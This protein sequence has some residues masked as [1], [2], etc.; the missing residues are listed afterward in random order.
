MN[1]EVKISFLGDLCPIN[2]VDNLV[3][4]NDL[5]NFSE[6]ANLL[7]NKDL[8]IAN[9]ECPLTKSKN[10]I[11]KIG[12]NLKGNPDSVKLLKYLSINLTAL[13]NNHIR[14]YGKQ[15][16]AD[17]FD[18]LNNNGIEYI[19]AGN[20]L[21]EARKPLIKEIKGIKIGFINICE[22]EFN[23]AGENDPGA[24]PD[25]LIDTLKT[26][27]SIRTLVDFSIL[28]Y[29]GGIEYYNLPS[30]ILQK[31][32]RFYASKGVDLIISHHT[33]IISGFEIFDNT[34]IFYGLGNFIFDMGKKKK[35]W[36]ETILINVK[37]RKQSK[38]EFEIIPLVQCKGKAGVFPMNTLESKRLLEDI[39]LLSAKIADDRMVYENFKNMTDKYAK[40]LY[41]NL[42]SFNKTHRRLMVRGLF[43]NFSLTQRKKRIL[44]NHFFCESHKE[45]VCETLKNDIYASRNF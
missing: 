36:H 11:K 40:Y 15:G 4:N 43:P 20:N 17:T 34:P 44:F 19:G 9:L 27:E 42:F 25:D 35:F 30:P 13:A 2:E 18:C 38:V 5:N 6:M 33:H 10:K 39:N 26:I 21:I 24:N 1:E 16:I 3:V 12:P 7:I 29:H 32:L 22:T 41:A 14:D 45:V 37:I 31:K 8:V 23:I 28:I